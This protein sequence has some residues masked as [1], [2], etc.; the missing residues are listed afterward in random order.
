MQAAPPSLKPSVT[1]IWPQTESFTL[2]TTNTTDRCETDVINKLE[3]RKKKKNHFNP[4]NSFQWHFKCSRHLIRLLSLSCSD[5]FD[6]CLLKHGKPCVWKSSTW[7]HPAAN[8]LIKHHHI[9]HPHH[10]FALNF[11]LKAL[12]NHSCPLPLG[13][14]Q[15]QLVSKSSRGFFSV[16][17]SCRACKINS[18]CK[19][20][21]NDLSSPAQRCLSLQQG[22]QKRA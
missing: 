7:T 5:M 17:F 22:E 1:S 11:F 8:Y 14:P 21:A 13:I 4:W 20:S 16:L 9:H 19:S 3:K 6:L 12:R 2:F 18:A 10:F 15:P